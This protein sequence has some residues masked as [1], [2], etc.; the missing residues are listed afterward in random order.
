MRRR[1]RLILAIRLPADSRIGSASSKHQVIAGT[2][3]A[4]KEVSERNLQTGAG[5][6]SG[7]VDD[8]EGSA[9]LGAGAHADDLDRA[10]RFL[11][12]N[13]GEGVQVQAGVD[14]Q[15]LVIAQR[16]DDVE[17]L[18]QGMLQVGELP[19]VPPGN[20]KPEV[21]RRAGGFLH[22]VAFLCDA[23]VE[24]IPD[25]VGEVDRDVGK[26]VRDVLA[27]LLIERLEQARAEAR[28]RSSSGIPEQ[29]RTPA[30]GVGRAV[31]VRGSDG[32]DSGVFGVDFL[33]ECGGDGVEVAG[34]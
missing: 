24:L 25:H 18:V 22:A 16:D 5:R 27:L 31:L 11:P 14:I 2:G 15:R 20:L 9:G 1:S 32:W 19:I 13:T 21:L 6:M 26:R 30:A 23:A 33:A 3:P 4:L 34:V 29:G 17:T 12:G 10:F 28:H 7:I 8:D